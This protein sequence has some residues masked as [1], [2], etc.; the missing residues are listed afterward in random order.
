MTAR[1]LNVG[2]I[3]RPD[4]IMWRVARDPFLLPDVSTSR[5]PT[6][7]FDDPKQSYAVRYLADSL[8]GCL[9]ET[10]QRFRPTPVALEDLLAAVDGLAVDDWEPDPAQGVDDWV[11]RQ[12]VGQL[13]LMEDHPVVDIMTAFDDL[14]SFPLVHTALRRSFPELAHLD[15]AVVLSGMRSGRWVTQAISRT[16]HELPSRPAGI[17]YPSRRDLDVTC[18]AVFSR[19]PFLTVADD[20]LTQT[21]PPHADAI[22][23][24]CRRYGIPHNTT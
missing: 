24:V 16:V 5:G 3:P 6:H 17:Q 8:Y 10:M 23:R 18:W 14:T 2:L 21:T 9:L 1:D 11:T 12:R 19:A 4:V 13:V 22:Q 7:R 20:A 15:A